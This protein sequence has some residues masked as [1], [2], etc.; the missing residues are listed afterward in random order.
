MAIK[1]LRIRQT[2]LDKFKEGYDILY[3]DHKQNIKLI[4]SSTKADKIKEVYH[5]AKKGVKTAVSMAYL[6]M[7]SN[8]DK[9]GEIGSY[10]EKTYGPTIAPIAFFVAL[11]IPTSKGTLAVNKLLNPE[12]N[13][14]YT[15]PSK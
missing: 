5:N 10:F 9:V 14:R 1:K 2:D 7:L 12:D 3:P 6:H 15:N 11:G 13:Q 8:V 4:N